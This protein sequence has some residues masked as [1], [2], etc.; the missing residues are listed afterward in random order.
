MENNE[1]IALY[2][3]EHRNWQNFI[4]FSNSERRGITV[5]IGIVILS[6]CF[7]YFVPLWVS[8]KQIKLF[9]SQLQ[10]IK[11]QEKSMTSNHGVIVDDTFKV[12]ANL[13]LITLNKSSQGGLSNT[14]IPN[15]EVK[16]QLLINTATAQ[17]LVESPLIEKAIAYRIVK[18]RDKLGGFHSLEQLKEVFE[19]PIEDHPDII[20]VVKLSNRKVKK[21]SINTSS[22]EILKAHPYISEKLANQ[23][24]NFRTKYKLFESADDVLK[25]YLV[26]ESLQ[27]K[28][29]HYIDYN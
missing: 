23:I 8:N 6:I 12:K 26:D 28:L 13:E 16:Q 20:N 5:L 29:V 4:Q 11:S 7:N 2:I 19:Y 22:I 17:Q 25:L 21:I 27:A 24:L 14:M 1:N 3:M 18:F 9:E 10:S 15:Q